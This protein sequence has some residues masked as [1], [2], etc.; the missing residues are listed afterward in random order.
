MNIRTI[1]LVI[2]CCAVSVAY[3]QTTIFVSS[4]AAN[5]NGNGQS[6]E[7]AKQTVAA[8]IAAAGDNGTVYV[9]AGSYSVGTQLSIPAGVSVK[10]GY[11]LALS[12]T[13]TT[14][15][16]L[17]GTNSRWENAG[18][19][20][21]LSGG[22]S[23]RIAVVNGLL[24]GCIVRNGVTTGQ[25]GGVLIDG[26][27]VRYCVIRECDAI[28][29]SARTAEGGGVYIRNGGLLTNCV[30]TECRADNGPAVAGGNSSLINNTI[31]RNWPSHC[32]KVSDYDGNVY[33]TVVIGQ[34]CWTHENLRTTHYNDGTAIPLGNNQPTSDS[35]PYYYVN[36]AGLT[37]TNLVNYGYL[38]NWPAVMHGAPSSND[39][40]SG[41]TGI[42][43]IGWHV[44]SSAEWMEM[45]NFVNSIT[46]YRC[47]GYDG[48]IGKALSSKSGWSSYSTDCYVG[49]NQGNNNITL[50]A[51]YPAGIYSGSSF[52]SFST[53]FFFWTTRESGSENAWRRYLY[54]NGYG[55]GNSDASKAEGYSVRCVK[56]LANS[57]PIVHTA[58]ILNGNIQSTQ[59]TCGGVCVD[60]GEPITA[61]GV[62]WSTSPNPT[63]EDSHTTDG[64][65]M[66]NF[67]TV[68]TGLTNGVTYY[69]RAYAINSL[70]VGYGEERV[71]TADDC[72]DPLN[73]T[74]YDGNQYNSIRI[75]TQCWMKENL[76]TTHFPDGTEIALNSHPLYSFTQSRYYP[77]NNANNVTIYGYLYTWPAI[78]HGAASS[79]ANPSGVQGICPNGWH[80]PSDAEW[81]QLTDYVS[82]HS[83]YIYDD[84]NTYIGKALASQSGWTTYSNS[85][86]SCY[87]GYNQEENNITGFTAMPAG[88][89][90]YYANEY[91]GFGSETILWS[92]TEQSDSYALYR[93]LNR[94]SCGVYRNYYYKSYSYS[95]RC[96]RNE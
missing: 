12:G 73:L 44:P 46:R 33:N 87:V 82:S 18:V 79:N 84:D 6:W 94:S 62:C 11:R 74:D 34:Q 50:F 3:A 30:V 57:A 81:T 68:I 77:G 51:A 42:C 39:N 59:A 17:P 45:R 58:E 52:S 80:V 65:G 55:F 1:I 90:T 8:G 72:G 20:T 61:Y 13:D 41:V 25:G 88:Y 9:K 63:I 60:G 29:E 35:L 37:S 7:T 95:V 83:E 47:N 28:H 70:G 75:G 66:A 5:D 53:G 36:Y 4:T 78:M 92:S 15:R 86:N 85:N 16:E 14:G 10:G 43:P 76:R 56:Q 26:G 22:G 2:M 48:H 71:F 40:P 31:T 38:Y 27:T 93:S 69:V 89:H 96:L 64:T 67:T 49:N 91:V 19:C 23:N 54:Y 24:E 21:I 32:G